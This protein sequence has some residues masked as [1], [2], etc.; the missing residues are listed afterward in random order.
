MRGL[1][2]NCCPLIGSSQLIEHWR[3]ERFLSDSRAMVLARAAQSRFVLVIH[4]LPGVW[5]TP[6][7]LDEGVPIIGVAAEGG[8]PPRI[9]AV[10]GDNGVE[11]IGWTWPGI[12]GL[13][14]SLS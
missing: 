5:P 10:L 3:R 2:G 6:L 14:D 9:P 13:I 1:P 12:E 4:H 7:R 8:D 11:V